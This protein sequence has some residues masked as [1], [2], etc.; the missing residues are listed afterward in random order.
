MQDKWHNISV[1][2]ES[3]KELQQIQKVIPI[4]VSIPQTIEW[5]IKIGQKQIKR[6]LLDGNGTNTKI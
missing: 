5:L 1:K 4:K 3:F 2:P 6:Q